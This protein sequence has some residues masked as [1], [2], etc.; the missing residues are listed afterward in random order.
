M[1][2]EGIT[3]FDIFNAFVENSALA[4]MGILLTPKFTRIRWEQIAMSPRDFKM[5]RQA[6]KLSR[7]ICYNHVTVQWRF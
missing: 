5:L 4:Y 7:D 2:A 1:K 6:C 3:Q